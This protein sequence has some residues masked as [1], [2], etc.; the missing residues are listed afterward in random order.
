MDSI[1]IRRA[2]PGD[3]AG[4]AALLPQLNPEDEVASPTSLEDSWGRIVSNPCLSYLV[5]EKDGVIVGACLLAILP[6][7]TRSTRPFGLIENVVVDDGHR[8]MGIAT[9]LLEHAK[10]IAKESGCYKLMLMSN[11]KRV[12]AHRLYENVGFEKASKAGFDLRL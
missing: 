7:L 6:N 10:S 3:L 5:A 4:V 2:D 8:R 12:E 9:R 11:N 1:L